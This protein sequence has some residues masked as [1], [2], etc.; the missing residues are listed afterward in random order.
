MN[1]FNLHDVKSIKIVEGKISKDKPW[2]DLVIT[3]KSGKEMVITAFHYGDAPSIIEKEGEG[4][5]NK[6]E[7][8]EVEYLIHFDYKQECFTYVKAKSATEARELVNY[9]LETEGLDWLDGHYETNNYDY[10]IVDLKPMLF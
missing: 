7:Q 4:E 2:T 5:D 8:E 1:T 3:D 10:E 6:Q 9:R